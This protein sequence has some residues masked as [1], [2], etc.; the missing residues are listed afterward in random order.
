MEILSNLFFNFKSKTNRS[1]VKNCDSDFNEFRHTYL[2]LMLIFI[3]SCNL[4]YVLASIYIYF[5]QYNQLNIAFPFL[6]KKV[7]GTTYFL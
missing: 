2:L 1:V 3:K 7:S 6:G 4:I 5:F